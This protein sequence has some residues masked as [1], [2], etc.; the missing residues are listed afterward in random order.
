MRP[1]SPFFTA[2]APPLLP[3]I[4]ISAVL[5]VL[6]TPSAIMESYIYRR[7]RCLRAPSC[8]MFSSARG[9]AVSDS[10]VGHINELICLQ[11]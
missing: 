8:F 6:L 2:S 5:M 3:I 9:S 10:Q 1:V 7:D 11:R 4:T